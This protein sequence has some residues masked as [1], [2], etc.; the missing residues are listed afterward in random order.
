MAEVVETGIQPG[1]AGTRER[2]T[3]FSLLPDTLV[4]FA[5]RAFDE[6]GNRSALSNV[7]SVRTR[8]PEQRLP[9]RWIIKPDGSGD[10]PT[11]QA[12]IDSAL[13]GDLVLV[14][15]GTYEE[16]I[17]FRGKNIT[18]RS[19]GGPEVTT[20]TWSRTSR[21]VVRFGSGERRQ[22]ILEG[23]RITGAWGGVVVS[24]AEPSILGNLITDNDSYFDG[25][26]IL[27]TAWDPTIWYPL[28]RGNTITNNRAGDRGGGI[29][30][31]E[32]MTPEIRDNVIEGNRTGGN[33]GGIYS[34][35]LYDGTMILGNRITA[36]RAGDQGG[37][38]WADH[39][40][41]GV[42]AM[43]ISGNLIESNYAA[44]SGGTEAS[45]GGM[46]LRRTSAWVHHNTIVGNTG[47]G[48]SPTYGGGIAV[49]S[50]DPL[51]EQNIIAL[52]GSG[53]GIR[54]GIDAAPEIRN[55]LV[56]RNEPTHGTGTCFDWPNADGNVVAD[57]S[58][59][60]AID[61]DF[62]LEEDSPAL[63]HPMGPLGAFPGAGCGPASSP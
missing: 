33:G 1:P 58:F 50:S 27:C 16:T 14:Y 53:G 46:W 11:V 35:G 13:A 24:N 6:A 48:V 47:D 54:C 23:F 45:G 8:T 55:N 40:D 19:A 60:D 31:L 37:G 20:L 15:P 62:R 17:E 41:V 42:R 52:S 28:I 34:L 26:G 57:P 18:V 56:W 4:Y 7:A 10:A 43:E 44:G 3:V 49:E 59:C 25:G 29:A 21:Y 51:I 36:N 22:A 61:G 38:I 32:S 2:T 12:G 63:T 5:V 39:A 9:G 30:C